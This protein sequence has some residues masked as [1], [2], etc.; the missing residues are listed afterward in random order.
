M[1]QALLAFPLLMILNA[2]STLSEKECHSS[3]WHQLGIQDGRAG[4]LERQLDD[5]T[6]S[7]KEYGVRPDIERYQAGRGIGLKQYCTPGNAFRTGLDGETYQGVC[8]A[9]IDMVFH[10]NN[11]AALSVYQ[12]RKRIKDLDSR[13][14]HL[15]HELAE[16]DKSEKDRLRLRKQIRD[17]D[18]ER[19]HLKSD[20]RFEEHELEIRMDEERYRTSQR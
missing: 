16:R 13:L 7:C 4:R 9:S 1:R 8:P 15:E 2:C 17:M 20:L 5:Y 12:A 14:D 3:D 6:Q 10:R 18:R 11:S 19:D